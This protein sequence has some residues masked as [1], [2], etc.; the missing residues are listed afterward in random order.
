MNNSGRAPRSADG[1]PRVSAVVPA[2]NERAASQGC[3]RSIQD[4]TERRLQIIVVDGASDDGA[5]QLVQRLAAEDPRIELL[6]NPERTV[7]YGLNRALAVARASLL[8]RVDAHT[9]VPPEHIERAAALLE[10]GSWGADG[11][12]DLPPRREGAVNGT[13]AVRSLLDEDREGPRRLGE[14][15]IV[16]QDFEFDHRVRS[17]GHR[18]RFNPTLVIDWECRQSNH[19]LFMQYRRYGRGKVKVA[20]RHPDSIKLR[21]AAPPALVAYLVPVASLSLAGEYGVRCFS[22]ALSPYG[23][24]LL[25]AT[26]HGWRNFEDP[27]TRDYLMPAFAAM[28][29]G[30]GIGFWE[31]DAQAMSRVRK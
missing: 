29:L 13:R 26:A 25:A 20:L 10:S 6:S 31:G 23:L 1:T 30:W 17:S 28:H 24:V 18:T 16:N 11:L 27:P 14:E 7:P 9:T 5:A 12:G 21:H 15:F 8:V 22:I 19:D 2:G 3:L 4:Q